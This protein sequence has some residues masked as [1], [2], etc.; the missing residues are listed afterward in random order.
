MC[1]TLDAATTATRK[2]V[3]TT[4]AGVSSAADN[5]SGAADTTDTA[6]VVLEC[7]TFSTTTVTLV[8]PVSNESDD[9]AKF[10]FDS[11]FYGLPGG[12]TSDA[13][14]RATTYGTFTVHTFV[15]TG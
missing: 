2:L 1:S 15:H 12:T 4:I 5:P 10:G 6:V 9:V 8:H 13:K 11:A 3:S 14:T 7:A